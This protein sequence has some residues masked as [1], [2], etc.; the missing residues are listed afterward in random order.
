MSETPLN[1]QLIRKMRSA[2]E[3]RRNLPQ[4]TYRLQFHAGFTFR[5]ATAIVPYLS[6]L[7]ITH[8]Y[9]SP[10]L[11]A[12]AGSTH[13]YDVIDHHSLNPEIG[14]QADYEAWLA[15]MKRHG[16]GHLLDTV[17]NHV[18]VATNDNAWWNDVLENGPASRYA[19]YFDIDWHGSPR[20]ELRDKVLLPVLGKPY[21]EALEAGEL[22]LKFENGKFGVHYYDR[23]FPIAPRTVPSALREKTVA[24]FNGT[25]GNPQ[26]FD[27]LDNLLMSQSYRLAY[28]RVAPD[29]IN[30][31]RFF[32]INDL[33]AL[34]MERP[35]V[36]NS[37]HELTMQWLGNGQLQG[38][39][40]DHPDG[41]YDPK[42]YFL[43]L[44]QAYLLAVAKAEGISLQ[45]LQATELARHLAAEGPSGRPL[46]VTV[47]K[48]LAMAEPLPA[49]WAVHG[50]SGYDFLDMVNGLFVQ[51]DNEAAF[52]GIYS[53]QAPGIASFEDLVYQNKRL[54][55]QIALAS[56]LHVLAH[57]LDRLAQV[58]RRSRDF[59]Q[60]GLKDALREVIACFPV[61]R[62][63]VSA[64]GVRP[65]DC[66]YV[67][68]AIQQAIAR[69]PSI[70]AAIFHFIRDMVLLEPSR[71]FDEADRAR[72]LKFAGKFQQLTAPVTAKGIEDTSFY[73]YNRL[74]SLNEVGGDPG[75]FGVRPE[76]LHAYLQDRQAH[77]PFALSPLS[78]HDTKR[79]EDV[80]ARINVLSEI[81]GEWQERVSTWSRLNAPLR[82]KLDG[83]DAPDSNDEYLLYQ[84][85]IG[86]WPLGSFE[87]E[88]ATFIARI[89]AYVEKAVR[90]AKVHT[91][92][93]HPNAGYEN[94]LKQFVADILKPRSEFLA[95]FVPFQAKISHWGMLNSLSQ[96]LLRLTAPGVPDTY[97]GTE[98]WDLSLVDPDN[99]R[100]VDY[101]IRRMM[102]TELAGQFNARTD[103]A[104]CLRQLLESKE[105]GRVKLLVTWLSLQQRRQHPDL[106]SFGQ[107]L[108]GRA[109]GPK[110]NHVFGFARVHDDDV[111]VTV[112]P[113]LCATL[114]PDAGQLPLTQVWQDTRLT[115]PSL[116][117]PRRLVNVFTEE[118]VQVAKDGSILI[119]AALQDFPVALLVAQ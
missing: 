75:Q 86:A 34:S 69:N 70:E 59:T 101:A 95:D 79:S 48:I 22:A 73:V 41:L 12:R 72:Q 54:I 89:Q 25:P 100:P 40:I 1:P 52:S 76:A 32:D 114:T 44:Q 13:G 61:Y 98:L 19:N 57:R 5:D 37:T 118:E 38:L 107:Y 68:Q 119:S 96:T 46:Y 62:S 71:F 11:K 92:W 24:H 85:L 84:T 83:I 6:E 87:A 47:E 49:D 104:T 35:E 106:F 97:Q 109:T 31:R 23:R 17:P 55:L 7:G 50:T 42:Q 60:T 113:K 63:Y 90:E 20:P 67:D 111:A 81:P 66:K 39:R 99:R 102:L 112:V 53:R 80:R 110:A 74:V 77:W 103:R 26:S 64:E 10:Y 65:D 94:A 29:E 116:R 78:T 36:F 15:E 14:T 117:L 9:A 30:Y 51:A 43:R 56:E 27:Q 45:P 93:T 58:D 33:A 28:W 21:A 16:M 115:V 3:A 108:P 2:V 8:C 82:Q 105:D 91:S 4:S 18:G 88:R